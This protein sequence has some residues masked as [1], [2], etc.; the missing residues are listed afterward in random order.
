MFS[1]SYPQ[2]FKMVG[3]T[4]TED[5]YQNSSMIKMIDNINVVI[6]YIYQ[7]ISVFNSSLGVNYIVLPITNK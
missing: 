3:Y 6:P 7:G 5:V 4:N 1:V 2:D